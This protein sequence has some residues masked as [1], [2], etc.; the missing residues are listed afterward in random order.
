[1]SKYLCG[2]VPRSKAPTATTGQPQGNIMPYIGPDLIQIGYN[3][4]YL[5]ILKIFVYGLVTPSHVYSGQAAAGA[6]FLKP[7]MF[8]FEKGVFWLKTD[9]IRQYLLI[10]GQYW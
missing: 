5:L 10:F 3:I 1:M 9:Y 2:L 8:V 6:F 4:K 7:G